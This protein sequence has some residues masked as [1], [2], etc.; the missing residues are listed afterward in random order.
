M[1]AGREQSVGGCGTALGPSLQPGALLLPQEGPA[2]TGPMQQ[3]QLW[4][5]VGTQEGPGLKAPKAILPLSSVP[6]AS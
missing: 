1:P 5:L 4:G 6:G 2:G 3:L